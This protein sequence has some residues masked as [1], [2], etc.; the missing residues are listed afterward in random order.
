MKL[1][2]TKENTLIEIEMTV[3]E[4]LQMNTETKVLDG[5]SVDQHRPGIPQLEY[6]ETYRGFKIY[7]SGGRYYRTFLG[8]E[9]TDRT[10]L[11]DSVDTI[12]EY[13][14]NEIKRMNHGKC[15]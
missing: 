12:K 1:T 9:W 2:I 6:L 10:E 11:F 14:D 7:I 3:E 5:F 13:I 4:Y 8:P 15:I